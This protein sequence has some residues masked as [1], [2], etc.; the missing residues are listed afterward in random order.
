MSFEAVIKTANAFFLSQS[1]FSNFQVKNLFKH[2]IIK[3]HNHK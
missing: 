3:K 1:F 2:F